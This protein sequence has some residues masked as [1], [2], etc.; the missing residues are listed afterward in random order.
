MQIRHWI[1]P[2]ALA[3]IAGCQSDTR[4]EAKRVDA[5]LSWVATAG[6]VT[7]GW[8][9]NRLPVRYVERVLREAHDELARNDETEGVRIVTA[10]NDAVR[11]R[12]PEATREPMASL[13]SRWSVLRAR[14][15]QL[16]SQ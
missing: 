10:L 16:K 7:K 12:A 14:S 11:R 5:S 15:E 1:G 13:V 8:V 9:E 4:R 6:T 2:F 3:L